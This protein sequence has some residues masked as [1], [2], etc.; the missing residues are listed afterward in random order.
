MPS[1]GL[2][3]ATAAVSFLV[4]SPVL[5]GTFLNW[6]DDRSLLGND[7]FRGLDPAHLHWMFTTTLLG[8]YAPLTWLSF[9]VTYAVAGMDPGA[10]HFGNLALHTLNAV[11][12]YLLA[13]RLLSIALPQRRPPRIGP[14]RLWPCWS[15]IHPL[16]VEARL[17]HRPRRRAVRD[18]LSAG[19]P[20]LRLLRAGQRSRAPAMADRSSP[21]SP[22]RCCPKR[23]R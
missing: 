22:P 15:S 13:S 16:R 23:S 11:L 2:V 7:G 17:D 14:A 10:Y 4:F 12:V 9:G 1:R 3:L 20:R 8:H 21:P 18:V 5:G 6:D 19:G